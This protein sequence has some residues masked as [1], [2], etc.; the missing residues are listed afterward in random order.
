MPLLPLTNQ[1]DGTVATEFTLTVTPPGSSAVT[2]PIHGI[3]NLTLPPRANANAKYTPISGPKA[4]K[5][6][7]VL[8]RNSAGSVMATLTYEK[9]H[10]LAID[11]VCGIDGC[12]IHLL[13]QDGMALTGTGGIER[14]GISQ[15]TDAKS[16]TAEFS[17]VLSAGWTLSDETPGEV[18][19]PFT[20]TLDDGEAEIDLTACGAD[21]ASD[22]SGLRVTR[23]RV[24][25]TATNGHSVTV[26]SG[27]SAGYDPGGQGFDVTLSPGTVSD[28]EFAA[29][30]AVSGTAKILSVTGTGTESITLY[31]EAA[32]P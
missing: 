30:G 16:M 12:E 5:E 31:I 17:F 32:A 26:A 19:L 1:F 11:A 27:V 23:L 22:L 29:G 10:Q 18:V 20:V 7:V 21:G 28:T 6:Q 15:V 9:K 2:I 14:I 8:F 13:A 25:A 24:L 4:G 3:E